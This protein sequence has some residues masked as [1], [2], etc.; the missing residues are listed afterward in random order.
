V[1]LITGIDESI[2]SV[3]NS[4]N[5]FPNPA[6]DV[7]TVMGLEGR[8]SIRIMSLTGQLVLEREMDREEVI[9]VD[10]WPRGIYVVTIMN[11]LSVVTK[12]IILR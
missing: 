8:A 3:P 11:N 7:I 2:K 9:S 6:E 5:I 4:P 10:G 12:K 1:V